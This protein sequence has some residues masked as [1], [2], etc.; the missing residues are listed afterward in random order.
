MKPSCKSLPT[1]SSS[2]L[3]SLSGFRVVFLRGC[4]RSAS[5]VAEGC[6][7]SV[8]VAELKEDLLDTKEELAEL[9]VV[10]RGLA[11]TSSGRAGGIPM[12]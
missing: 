7:C 5:V 9:H 4:Y 8:R 12:S 1:V 6:R 3:V 2:L 11:I 10:A